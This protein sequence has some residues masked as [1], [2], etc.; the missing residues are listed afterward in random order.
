MD[1]KELFT[2]I[3][4]LLEKFGIKA[5]L[6]KPEVVETIYN[7]M[8]QHGMKVDKNMFN[9]VVMGFASTP[10]DKLGQ[11]FGTLAGALGGAA[12]AAGQSG[13]GAA[14]NPLAAILGAVAQGSQ[15]GT[16]PAATP[17]QDQNA[18]ANP[19]AA[20]GALGA[21]AGALGGTAQAQP[22]QQAQPQTGATAADLLGGIAKA[23]LNN[24]GQK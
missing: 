3:S 5:A 19:L 16:Q 18:A 2:K 8:S 17:S 21:L 14:A 22:Q 9:L 4:E 12:Q 11:V 24:Q 15:S 23:V 20:L 1:T 7:V 10:S 6:Q 13:Q